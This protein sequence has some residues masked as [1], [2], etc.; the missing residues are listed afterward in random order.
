MRGGG[1]GNLRCGHL[2]SSVFGGLARDANAENFCVLDSRFTLAVRA[3]SAAVGVCVG[4]GTCFRKRKNK[5][6]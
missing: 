1:E 2:R 4:F 6:R 5:N 3:A